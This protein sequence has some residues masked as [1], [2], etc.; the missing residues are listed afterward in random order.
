MEQQNTN[1]SLQT[2]GTVFQGVLPLPA[3]MAPQQV[4]DLLKCST[5]TVEEHARAGTLP[6][7][8]FGDG[9]VFPA[10]ALLR[11]INRLAEAGAAQRST[12]PKAKAVYRRARPALPELPE[13]GSVGLKSKKAG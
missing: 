8:K 3:V 1:S 10:D 6:G 9:W 2:S 13:T 12:P 4:A 7:V 5:R 11:A